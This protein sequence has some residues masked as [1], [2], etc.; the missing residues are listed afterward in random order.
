M[1]H[2]PKRSAEIGIQIGLFFL[3]KN[4]GDYAATAELLKDL[5]IT[6]IWETDRKIYVQTAR[7]G[8]FIGLRGENLD[9]LAKSLGKR[10]DVEESFCWA[11]IITPID[12]REHMERSG[13]DL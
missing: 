8:L 11:D 7:P 6:D 2:P 9:G 10:V 1:K 5:C 3:E 12:W 4:K 13:L